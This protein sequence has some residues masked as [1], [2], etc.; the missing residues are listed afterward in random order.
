M[1]S[2]FLGDFT[3]KLLIGERLAEMVWHVG[4]LYW[5]IIVI[6]FGYMAW[7]RIQG[8]PTCHNKQCSHVHGKVTT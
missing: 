3:L 6:Y 2:D 1:L 7:R 4:V 5:G 8:H